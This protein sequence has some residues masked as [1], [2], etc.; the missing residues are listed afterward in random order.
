MTTLVRVA[1]GEVGLLGRREPPFVLG[2]PGCLSD[3][4]VPGVQCP[5][6]GLEIAPECKVVQEKVIT[7]EKTP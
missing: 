4:R 1:A 5:A 3:S 2:S 7:M 6:Q